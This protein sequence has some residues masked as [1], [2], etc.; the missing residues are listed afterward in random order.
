[1]TEILVHFWNLNMQK[2]YIWIWGGNKIIY[3]LRCHNHDIAMSMQP[4]PWQWVHM[5]PYSTRTLGTP[6]RI[7][8]Q[9]LSSVVPH[10]HNRNRWVKYDHLHNTHIPPR[11]YY[12]RERSF[13]FLPFFTFIIWHPMEY[14]MIYFM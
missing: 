2:F 9:G 14:V 10:L 5:V 12:T 6:P 4:V 13:S 7:Y 8:M 11:G 3:S 1:M